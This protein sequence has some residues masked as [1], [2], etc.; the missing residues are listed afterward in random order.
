MEITQELRMIEDM[1][2]FHFYKTH[3]AQENVNEYDEQ[4]PFFEPA[5][6]Y[7]KG[8]GRIKNRSALHEVD[9]L[10][11]TAQKSLLSNN[12]EEAMDN[13]NIDEIS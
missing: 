1:W 2:A 5:I 9:E 12:Q 4:H 13:D 6:I 11:L 8:N 3:I 10:V 7:G